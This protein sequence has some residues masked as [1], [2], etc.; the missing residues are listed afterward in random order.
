MGPSDASNDI[1][2][3]A[4]DPE[5]PSPAGTGAGAGSAGGERGEGGSLLDRRFSRRTLMKGGAVTAAAAGVTAWGLDPWLG[6]AFHYDGQYVFPSRVVNWPGVTQVVS[7][8]KQCHSDCALVGSVFNGVL[9]KLD[10]S[11]Y[12]PNNTQP[13]APY[14]TATDVAAT[15][16]SQHSLCPR[17]HAG[18]QTVYDPY[19]IVTP[20]KRTGPRG[21]GQWETIGWDQL[22]R[23]VVGGGRLF[24]HVPGEEDRHV[25]GFAELWDSGAARTAPIDPANPDFG[26][27]TNGLVMFWGRAEDGENNFIKRFGAAFGTVNTMPHVAICDLN[28]HVATELAL[29]PTTAMLKPDIQN[30]QFIIWFGA[31]ITEANFPMQT[32]GRN[33]AEANVRGTLKYVMVDVRMGNA[34]LFADQWVVVKPGGDGALAMGM[35]REIIEH[36]TY[37]EAF[38]E[39][40]SATA[41]TAAGEPNFSNATWLVITQPGHPRQGQFLVGSDIGQSGSAATDQVVW[42]PASGSAVVATAVSSAALWPTGNLSTAPVV[43]GG[44]EC[45]TSFQELYQSAQTHSI[46]GYARLA[47]VS[48]SVITSLAAEFTAH[49]RQAVADF[50]RGPVMHTNGVQ[51]GRAIMTLNFLVGN[52]DWAGGY[53][54][55]GGA[56]DFMGSKAGAVYDLGTWPGQ[57]TGVPGGVAISREGSF[58]E[59][60]DAYK[61]AVSAGKSPFPAPRPWF[62]FGV[63]LWPEIF[64]G[65]YQGYPYPI[66]ILFQH[67]ANPAWSTPGIG[68]S[69]DAELPWHRLITD[70]DKVPLYIA[71]DIVI[72]ESSAYADYIV[73]DT[74]YLEDWGVP[75]GYP[76]YPTTAQGVR[77]PVI[78]PLTNTT[79]AGYPICME[80]FLIDVAKA[81]GLPGFGANAFMEGG[82]LDTRED[83]YL[84]QVANIAYDP[85]FHVP[86]ATGL[87]PSGPVP[88]ATGRD[89]ETVTRLRRRHPNALR[90]SEW[91]KVAYVLAR[92]GRFEDFVVGYEPNPDVLRTLRAVIDAQLVDT[93]VE[94]WARQPGQ[95]TP[96]ELRRV[97]H[98]QLDVLAAAPQKPPWTAHRWGSKGLPCQIYNATAAATHN[99]LTGEAFPGTASYEPERLMDGTLVDSVDPRSSFPY[100]MSTHKQPFHSKSRTIADP[101]LLE[102]MPE[103][104]LEVN[105]VDA[106]RLGVKDGDL[107]KV[108]SP[109]FPK[110]GTGRVRVM[111]GVRPGVVTYA[112][113]FGHWQYGSG[114][115]VVN[116]KRFEGD[117]LRNAP[118]HLVQATR[119]DPSLAGGPGWTIAC[120][121][122]IGGGVAYFG[123]RVTVERV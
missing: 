71:S 34:N 70:L 45:R 62:P 20:L 92:G 15:W 57:P 119:L 104:L 37:N 76:T 44:I 83:F 47:G 55:G 66:K 91:A 19:R 117:D 33:V 68:G 10:G 96:R 72:A 97:F 65:A 75:P 69:P 32:L 84:K 93:G 101:W 78:E 59:Q 36:G 100:V 30:A 17:G 106:E 22:I 2:G 98:R 16:P 105:P 87:A 54:A 35:I 81:T 95:A 14:A 88:D 26:P 120:E 51:A 77:Q 112:D 3:P 123:T 42:D 1:D 64:A 61:A 29:D 28:H 79:P 109:T 7:V 114:T 115:W 74:S 23:E 102:L 43:A 18:R 86:S 12:H 103:A 89:L 67:M 46:E 24:S 50:Y 118:F 52:I 99:A 6:N 27:K 5:G 21:S 60:S 73:P 8:C 121:D 11:A 110:G 85:T 9:E 49:G 108:A 38:L 107:V 94:A 53:I 31:N 48:P 40:P 25:G 111:A 113:A 13:H 82:S 4:T 90:P 39:V 122:P 116:G 63:G 41:A 56:A 80:Q 58:Y